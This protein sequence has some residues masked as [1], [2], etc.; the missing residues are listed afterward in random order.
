LAVGL[1]WFG[2]TIPPVAKHI[3]PYV[4]MPPVLFVGF[5]AVE[6]DTV[7]S[8]YLTNVYGSHAA[9]ANAPMCFL[10]AL[11]SGVFPIIGRRMFKRMGSSGAS[12][13]LAGL[14]TAFVGVAAVFWRYG[15]AIR[16]R[17]RFAQ[18]TEEET[19]FE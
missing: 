4:S 16:R 11:V 6:F 17:S 12:F 3:S 13:L 10:R 14:A 18:I 7:L 5:A 15:R 9:S 19:E 2:A 1:W 8:G